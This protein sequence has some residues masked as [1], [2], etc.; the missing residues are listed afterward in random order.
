[1]SMG[2]SE[3]MKRYL[4]SVFEWLEDNYTIVLTVGSLRTVFYINKFGDEV[5]SVWNEDC[6]LTWHMKLVS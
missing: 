1:M 2:L 3:E 6:P 5:K 4:D